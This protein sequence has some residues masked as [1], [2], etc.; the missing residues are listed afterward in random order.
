MNIKCAHCKGYHFSVADVRA[1]A[2]QDNAAKVFAEPAAAELVQ[3]PSSNRL[4]IT[5]PEGHY[6]VESNSTRKFYRVA[7]PTEGRWAGYTFV[8]M[9][10]SDDYYPI[11]TSSNKTRILE[12]I[13]Q[14]PQT[15]MLNYGKWL[16]RCGHCGRTLTNMDSIEAGIGPICRSRMGW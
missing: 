6:A 10:V 16:G 15:A 3:S 1:C 7:R 5:V 4:Q 2:N 9:Q 8:D 14:D 12:Q 11:R 13:A